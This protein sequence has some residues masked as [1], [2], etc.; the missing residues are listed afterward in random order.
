M[1]SDVLVVGGG[2][3]GCAIAS[4]CAQQGIGVRLLERGRLAGAA[5]SLDLALLGQPVPAAV[6]A[7]ATAS[8]EAYLRLHHFTGQAFF[9]DRSPLEC[10]GSEALVRRIDVP[11]AVLALAD[12]AR[13]YRAEI[14]TGCDVKSLIVRG[15]KALGVRT[16]SGELRAAATVVAA[17]AETWR[18]CRGLTTHVP[19]LDVEGVLAVYPPGT[20]ALE[21]PQ[22]ADGGWAAPDAA[23]R[24]VV[25]E[26]E[27]LPP[28]GTLHGRQ[29]LERR[30]LRYATTDDGLPLHGPLPGVEGLAVACGHGLLGVELAPAAGLAI[31]EAL[32]SDAWDDAFLPGRLLVPL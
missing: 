4:A 18:V 27:R 13:A 16:D 11:G 15:G 10:D 21:R 25:A 12:E 5:S 9:L 32:A 19:L 20:V 6:E 22:L 3:V 30:A 24:A 2:I 14:R 23:D 1:T 7:M 28:R 8:E 31:A 29:P 26:P 17:G